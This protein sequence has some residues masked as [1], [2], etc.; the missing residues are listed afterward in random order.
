MTHPALKNINVFPARVAR[1]A[2]ICALATFVRRRPSRQTPERRN[3]DTP[4]GH[5]WKESATEIIVDQRGGHVEHVQ[6]GC[7]RDGGGFNHDRGCN[8]PRTHHASRHGRDAPSSHRPKL[9]LIVA[10]VLEEGPSETPTTWSRRS[11]DHRPCPTYYAG[12]FPSIPTR[13]KKRKQRRGAGSRWGGDYTPGRAAREQ[14]NGRAGR[15][16]QQ[17]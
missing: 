12:S 8:I 1:V 7:V 6:M 10:G 17:Y 15:Q 9:E 5:R 2:C 3:H 14:K 4:A 16:Q 13:P 11:W